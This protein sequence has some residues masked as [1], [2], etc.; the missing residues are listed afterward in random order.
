MR[1]PVDESDEE[2]LHVT[3]PELL[4]GIR[5][6]GLRRFGLLARDVFAYWGIKSTRDF[7]CVVFEL[8]ERGEMRKTD[9]DQLEDFDDVY[10]FGVVL[11]AE[12]QIPTTVSP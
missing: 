8:I 6:L 3:G 12:Y 4:A 5:E 9:D 1:Q 2:S 10:C 7:G 11:D